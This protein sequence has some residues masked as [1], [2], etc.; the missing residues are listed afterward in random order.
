MVYDRTPQPDQVKVMEEVNKYKGKV[1]V[2]ID[3]RMVDWG[4]YGQKCKL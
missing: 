4:D 2:T 1:G 3:L